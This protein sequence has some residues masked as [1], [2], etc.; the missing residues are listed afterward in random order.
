MT[1]KSSEGRRA[2]GTVTSR[3][4]GFVADT[5]RQHLHL[6]GLR[7]DRRDSTRGELGPGSG[8]AGQPL[9]AALSW[10]L[11]ITYYLAIFSTKPEGSPGL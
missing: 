8:R 3:S 4:L 6:L 5:V 10:R 7:G 9:K 11:L 1:C 2:L